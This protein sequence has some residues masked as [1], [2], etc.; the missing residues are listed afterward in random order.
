MA[1]KS[2]KKVRRTRKLSQDRL[3]TLLD[4]EIRESMIKIR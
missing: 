4:K 3:I 1:S 2:L